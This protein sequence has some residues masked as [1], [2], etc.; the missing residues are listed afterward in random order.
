MKL[1][2]ELKRLDDMSNKLQMF[3]SG[4]RVPDDLAGVINYAQTEAEEIFDRVTWLEMMVDKGEMPDAE[5]PGPRGSEPESEG[6][7]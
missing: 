6:R 1:S 2:E 4:L 3:L 7:A 5:F